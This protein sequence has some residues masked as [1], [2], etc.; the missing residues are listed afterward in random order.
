MQIFGDVFIVHCIYTSTLRPLHSLVYAL[1]KNVFFND[2]VLDEN[3]LSLDD[4][5]DLR[6]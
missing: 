1:G 3:G 5:A 2:L 4:D 6:R